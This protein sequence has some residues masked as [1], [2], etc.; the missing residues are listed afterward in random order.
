MSEH[1]NLS[2]TDRHH[3]YSLLFLL[4]CSW[5][6][7]FLKYIYISSCLIG[8]EEIVSIPL[9]FLRIISTKISIVL[10]YMYYRNRG[11]CDTWRYL[12]STK[13]NSVMV[14]WFL[15]SCITLSFLCDLSLLD[16]LLSL[17]VS[18]SLFISSQL[19]NHKQSFAS[20]WEPKDVLHEWIVF[21]DNF[22]YTKVYL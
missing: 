21:C 5:V 1:I 11:Y 13:K 12:L 19:G 20:T 8:R 10:C 22:G 4:Q 18:I 3:S 16:N 15:D 7:N 9:D 6:T 17:V 2:H 14:L